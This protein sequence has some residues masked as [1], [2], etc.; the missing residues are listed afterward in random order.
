MVERSLPVDIELPSNGIAVA[1]SV[2]ARDFQMAFRQDTYNKLV[3]VVRGRTRLELESGRPTELVGGWMAPVP[4]GVPHRLVDSKPSTV[5]VL[6]IGDSLLAEL[7]ARRS[8]WDRIAGYG[9]FCPDAGTLTAVTTRL[10]SILHLQHV[11][12]REVADRHELAVRSET[13]AILASLAASDHHHAGRPSRE[14]VRAVLE[15]ISEAPFE[16]WTREQAAVRAGLS[17]RRFGDLQREQTGAPFQRWL[18]TVRVHYAARLISRGGYTASAAAFAS[19]FSSL[20]TFYRVFRT[21]IGCP[22]GS[23]SQD[24]RAQYSYGHVPDRRTKPL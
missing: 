2:H 19:G 3:L 13:D 16:E 4:E 17:V 23:L 7:P 8:V 21:V 15:R 20:P 5:V 14:R 18:S 24:A 9:A 12:L 6:A 22:P 10:R 11:R 1:E